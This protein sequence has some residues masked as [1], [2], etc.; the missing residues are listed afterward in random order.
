[1][2]TQTIY[3]L[4]LN[5]GTVG[6]TI[7]SNTVLT[8]SKGGIAKSGA[9]SSTISGSGTANIT[10][11]AGTEWVI[12]AFDPLDQLTISVPINGGSGLTKSGQ[13]V[14]VLNNASNAYGGTTTIA[15][16]TIKLGTNNVIPDASNLV[17]AGS[18]TIVGNT[19][20]L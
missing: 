15:Q 3:T 6:A 10:T 12:Y 20:Q 1:T 13:G 5:G 7:N 14:L 11:G 17:I 16:G 2:G 19:S 8:L 18:T 4:H 9:G